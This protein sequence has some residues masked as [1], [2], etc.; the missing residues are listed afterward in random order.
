MLTT[1][2]TCDCKIF[3]RFIIR[4]WCVCG[5]HQRLY[6]TVSWWNRL[7]YSAFLLWWHASISCNYPGET[8]N[9]HILLL[10]NLRISPSLLMACNYLLF[11]HL[12]VRLIQKLPSFLPFSVTSRARRLAFLSFLWMTFSWCAFLKWHNAASYWF[13][14]EAALVCKFV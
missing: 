4:G 8:L 11:D 13:L 7:L 14:W 9:T 1:T 6:L 5:R 10:I 2:L 3:E 12:I